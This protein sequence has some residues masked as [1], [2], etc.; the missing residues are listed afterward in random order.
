MGELAIKGD[1]HSLIGEVSSGLLNRVANKYGTTK[2]DAWMTIQ[3]K[4]V[5][6]QWDLIARSP[7]QIQD[8]HWAAKDARGRVRR[9][10]GA[11]TPGVWRERVV[12]EKGQRDPYVQEVQLH[13]GRWKA[14][15][16]KGAI[17]MGDRYPAWVTRH[18]AYVAKDSVFKSDLQDPNSQWILF[19]GRGPG[20]RRDV[21]KIQD[22]L[23]YRA[24]AI[25]K[26]VQLIISGYS[27]DIANKIRPPKSRAKEHAEPMEEL[28]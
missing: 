5:N 27:K 3:G 23:R 21:Q 10:K 14:K 28:D 18:L 15:W 26:R 22:A 19:G 7:A 9:T 1:L 6:L 25:R 2:I 13:V 4:S 17:E 12:V 20:F 24:Q 8:A 16:A 11:P